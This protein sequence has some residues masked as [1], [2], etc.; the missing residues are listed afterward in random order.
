MHSAP[1]RLVVTG[2]GTG[3]HTYPALTA[4]RTLQARLAGEGRALDVLWIGTTDGLEA[5]VAPAEGIAFTTVATGKIRRS[6]NPIKMASPANVKDMARVPLGVLQARRA[7][8]RFQPD[9]VLAT[10]GYVAVPAGL[11]AR[12]CHRPLVLHEQT[13]RLGLA[14]RKLAS[15]AARICVSSESTLPLLSD[16]ARAV[17]T[18]N[19]VRPEVLSGQADRAVQALGLWGFDRSL[20]TVY[21]TG[22][23]QGSQQ[24]NELVGEV[25]PWLLQRANVIHQCGPAN[26]A[27]LRARAAGLPAELAARYHLAGFVSGELPDVLALADVVVSRS[28]AGT[29][30]ELTALGKPAVFVP[31]ASSAGNEQVH[32][33]RHLEQAGAAVALTGEVTA[34]QLRTAVG[35]LLADVRLRW[36]MAERAR[37]YGRPDAAD[38][39]VDE[40][41]SAAAGRPVTAGTGRCGES[42]VPR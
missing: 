37:A 40:I 18:G 26:E 14:N 21:V 28:G 4:V 22:G 27:A 15:A 38:R 20:P 1:F 3:G 10:G 2:G 9:V 33:A 42:S 6:K 5:R 24:I 39:L 31:L 13:V 19:P 8:D 32:N 35:P 30:A 7:I 36:G 41:L 12:M 29:L 11:A 17:V 25:L 34:A 16:S 23:A